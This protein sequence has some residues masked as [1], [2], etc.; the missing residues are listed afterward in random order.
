MS[1]TGYDYIGNATINYNDLFSE[2]ETFAKFFPGA[3]T[4]LGLY[5]NLLNANRIGLSYRWDYL[6]TGKKGAHRYDH[7][8]HSLNLSFMFRIN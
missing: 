8:L 5:L 2:N 1:R 3:R 7:A 4:E 6:T